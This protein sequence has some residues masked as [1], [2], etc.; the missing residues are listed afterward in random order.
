M[1]DALQHAAERYALDPTP[2]S[3]S[4]AVLAGIGLVRMI[5][6]R[7]HIP[8][9]P[10]ATPEDLESV[11]IMGLLQGL[12]QYI[13]ER[14]TPFSSFVYGRIRGALVDYLRSIDPLPRERRKLI[15]RL[16]VA[17][18]TLQQ[19][20]QGQSPSPEEVANHL[21]ISVQDYHEALVHAQSRYSV[22]L[23]HQNGPGEDAPMLIDVLP[24]RDV[25]VAAIDR[26]SMSDHVHALMRFL[27]E[28]D[29]YVLA[30]YYYEEITLREIARLIGVS[31]ARVSQI[32][33]RA[34][35]RLRHTVHLHGDIE[36]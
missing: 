9:H 24:N 20:G 8:D 16:Q 7:F 35:N 22:S 5:M 4:E 34:L 26:S 2:E 28:R 31:E 6:S 23:H 19:R 32:L 3:R 15:A 14:G 27:P 25:S 1:F 12:D 10:L 13:P 36:Q 33:Q 18:D 17:Q 11:G 29:Q 30:L 21:G